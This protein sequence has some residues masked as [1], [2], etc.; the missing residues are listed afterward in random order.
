MQ[1]QAARV[2]IFFYRF[3]IDVY[4]NH[5]YFV[6][7]FLFSEAAFSTVAS[8]GGIDAMFFVIFIHLSL[9]FDFCKCNINNLWANEIGKFP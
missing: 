3:P 2:L 6:V 8:L 5:L 4:N 7:Y 9:Q 1:A